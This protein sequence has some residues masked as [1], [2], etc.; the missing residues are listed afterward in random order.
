MRP[1][2]V[3]TS[4]P[5]CTKRKMLSTNSSTSW[6]CTSRKYSAMVNAARPTRRRTPG[7]SSIWP[8][9]SAALSMTPDSCISSH[10]S[11]PSRVRSP[12][13]ANTD[14]PPCCWATRWIISWMMTVLPT[15]APPKRPIFPPCTWLEQVDH[16]DPRLEHLGP[17]L[18]LVEGGRTAVDLPVVVHSL[19][20]VGVERPAQHV[21]DVAQ[22]GIAHGDRD[23]TTQ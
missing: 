8:Y 22:H 18:Q 5:A 19:D 3:E 9:T 2:R 4:E 20:L 11:V 17:G 13:P 7:G 12:T 10:M 16:L 23:A 14:T 6:F 1:S 15:P 21:E